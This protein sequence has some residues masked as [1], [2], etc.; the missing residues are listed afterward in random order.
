MGLGRPARPVRA[1]ARDR[2]EHVET[3]GRLRE[4]R[5]TSCPAASVATKIPCSCCL[6]NLPLRICSG[7]GSGS[8]RSSTVAPGIGFPSGPTTRSSN[9]WPALAG[10]S[11]GGRGLSDRPESPR[12]RHAD[13]APR[14]RPGGSGPRATIRPA[15]C[16][17]AARYPATG[18]RGA[19]RR[20]A[21]PA[22]RCRGPLPDRG[23]RDRHARKIRTNASP[24]STAGGVAQRDGQ[25]VAGVFPQLIDDAIRDP[26]RRVEEVQDG[27]ESLEHEDDQVTAPDM[28]Q[29]VEQDPAQLLRL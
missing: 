14:R 27:G 17:S 6:T 29:L 11:L 20:P 25:V 13:G 22:R 10:T 2:D 5:P 4:A 9:S 18:E 26:D 24:D 15:R 19:S 21:S 1:I 23:G 7:V 12:R 16:G 3:V 8:P 28:G